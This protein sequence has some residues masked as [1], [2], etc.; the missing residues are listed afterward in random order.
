LSAEGRG[1]RK[2]ERRS[3]S[4]KGGRGEVSPYFLIQPEEKRHKGIYPSQSRKMQ[5]GKKKRKT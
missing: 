5:E 4:A 1:G 2:G 3:L